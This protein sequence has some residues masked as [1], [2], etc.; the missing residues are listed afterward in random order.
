MYENKEDCGS[1]GR[2]RKVEYINFGVVC[3]LIDAVD[4]EG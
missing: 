4:K 1:G 3:V 2:K